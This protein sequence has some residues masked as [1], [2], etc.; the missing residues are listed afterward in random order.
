MLCVVCTDM[1]PETYNIGKCLFYYFVIVSG[2]KILHRPQD[3]PY[4]T[5]LPIVFLSYP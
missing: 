2:T 4:L 1:T 5:S 3:K